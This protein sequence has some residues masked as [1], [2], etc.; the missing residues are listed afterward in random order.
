MSN[1]QM[2][3]TLATICEEQNRLIKAIALRLGE[4]GDTALRDEIAEAD[5]KYRDFLGAGEWP[6]KAAP[7]WDGEN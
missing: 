5:R 6:E 3:A 1:L 7:V 2:I 4:L